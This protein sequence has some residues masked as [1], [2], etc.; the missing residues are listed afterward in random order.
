MYVR[1]YTIHD[2]R[3]RRVSCIH[4]HISGVGDDRRDAVQTLLISNAGRRDALLVAHGHSE[5]RALRRALLSITPPRAAQHAQYT[6]FAGRSAGLLV[7]RHE[8]EHLLRRDCA[9][10]RL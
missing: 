7:G 4:G 8:P 10:L 9:H 1:V 6:P 3:Y 5:R 2:T